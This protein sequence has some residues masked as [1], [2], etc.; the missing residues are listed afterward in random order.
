MQALDRAGCFE[1]GVAPCE[2]Q[3]SPLLRC[4][5]LR[6]DAR[7]ARYSARRGP[8]PGEPIGTGVL[9]S[10]SR[11]PVRS[12]TRA[13][14]TTLPAAVQKSFPRF[15]SAAEPPRKVLRG[16]HL[17]RDGD[18]V[19]PGEANSRGGPRFAGVFRGTDT[20]GWGAIVVPGASWEVGF[21]R[22]P[23]KSAS[24][25]GNWITPQCRDRK[26]KLTSVPGTRTIRLRAQALYPPWAS[27]QGAKPPQGGFSFSGAPP[28][29]S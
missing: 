15:L 3:A 14:V 5:G 6:A 26:Q 29:V 8:R 24:G 1:T 28:V 27:V 22:K 13:V 21:D 19:D 17:G 7:E 10:R 20:T 16:S 12:D 23:E 11:A 4:P 9:A 2:E 25:R 18:P